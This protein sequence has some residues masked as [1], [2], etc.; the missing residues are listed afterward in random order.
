MRHPQ[1]GTRITPLQPK[2]EPFRHQAAP[3]RPPQ[4]SETTAQLRRDGK[5]FHTPSQATI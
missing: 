1:A 4:M 2:D 3:A 5:W